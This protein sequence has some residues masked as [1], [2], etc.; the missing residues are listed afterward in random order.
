MKK[1]NP[2]NNVGADDSVC[3]RNKGITLIALIITIIVLLILTIVSIRLI[4]N[5]GFISKSEKAV[6]EYELAQEEENVKLA[7]NYAKI[8]VMGGALT[9]GDLTEGLNNQNLEP[10][11]DLAETAPF[12]FK[13]KDGTG[14]EYIIMDDGKI[15]TSQ[16]KA[17]DWVYT[18]TGTE[19]RITGCN[20]TGEKLKNVIIPKYLTKEDGT[21]LTVTQLGNGSK[22]IANFS[23]TLVAPNDVTIYQYAFNN[24]PDI[25]KVVFGDNTTTIRDNAG[26][27]Q[28]TSVNTKLK[29]VKIGAGSKFEYLTFDHC[30]NIDKV[31]IGNNVYISYSVIS[32]C[33]VSKVKIG[34]NV[35]IEG[36][37]FFYATKKIEEIVIGDNFTSTGRWLAGCTVGKVI[38]GKNVYL[39]DN[40]LSA[41][42]EVSI[43]EVI[44]DK[45]ILKLGSFA[46]RV[47]NISSPNNFIE[48]VSKDGKELVVGQG[49]LL[50]SSKSNIEKI[51]FNG[52]DGSIKLN[53]GNH[54]VV[55]TSKTIELRGTI[56]SASGYGPFIGCNDVI[57]SENAVIGENVFSR[58]YLTTLIINKNASISTIGSGISKVVIRDISQWEE[59]KLSEVKEYVEASITKSPI[60]DETQ[61]TLTYT[62]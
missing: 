7:V 59:E 29:D 10:D 62:R 45:T 17:E 21:I 38:I 57:I 27:H 16:A 24:C 60:K 41:Q 23:G 18:V 1:T 26:T 50:L 61:D 53:A 13:I 11:R 14:K 9:G 15:G 32:Y 28:F 51:I 48:I 34:D 5:E 44:I 46:L 2:I 56:N 43:D 8:K 49:A 54:N 40:G 36:N 35:T 12:T 47:C 39:G 30:P 19:A 37:A 58:S 55:S 31:T 25:E 52:T 6:T 22:Q 33:S 3:P 42:S 20:L 4:V